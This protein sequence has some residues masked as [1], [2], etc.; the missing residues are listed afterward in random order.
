MFLLYL[1]ALSALLVFLILVL[2]EFGLSVVRRP[3]CVSFVNGFLSTPPP[4]PE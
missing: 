3:G 1:S 2:L 4:P